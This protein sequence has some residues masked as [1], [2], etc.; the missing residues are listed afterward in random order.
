MMLQYLSLQNNDDLPSI[1]NLKP[2]KCVVLVS[3]DVSSEW[4][5]TVSKWLVD[6]GCLY[7]IAWGVDCSSWDDSV[8]WANI[9]AFGYKS[10]PDEV[11]V[12]TSWF[13]SESLEEVL[14][15]SKHAAIALT[16]RLENVLFLDIGN[17]G[18]RAFL[19][20]IYDSA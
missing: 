5:A 3:E 8:D 17:S 19:R 15:F 20:N 18:R 1:E 14:H 16:G 9:E 2:F 11:F 12:R 13:E 7:M 10:I 6:A 4:Q